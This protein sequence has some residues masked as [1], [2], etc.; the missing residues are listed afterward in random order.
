V[1]VG[2]HAEDLLLKSSEAMSNVGSFHFEVTGTFSVSSGQAAIEVPLSYV[3]DVE[4]PDK[5]HGLVSL[6]VVVFALEMEI[7]TIGD[8]T[9]T[10]NPESGAWEVSEGG[11]L[12]I[13]NPADFSLGGEPPLADSRFLPNEFRDG[14]N[15]HTLTGTARFSTLDEATQE[16]EAT[17]WIGVDDLLLR[18]ISVQA[19][20]ALDA[21]GLPVDDVGLGGAGTIA[22]SIKLSDFGKPVDIEAPIIR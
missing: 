1:S 2:I 3:G 6:S 13:P 19:D 8:M 9:Y 16:S 21:M 7:I 15:V 17:I 10:T 20:V 18:E 11:A 12:G 14:R 5:S 22:L 4:V